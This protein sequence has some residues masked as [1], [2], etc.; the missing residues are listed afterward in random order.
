[1]PEPLLSWPHV[2]G[3][4]IT[5][6]AMQTLRANVRFPHHD[7]GGHFFLPVLD[8]NPRSST[9]SRRWSG[10]SVTNSSPELLSGADGA[11]SARWPA[12]ATVPVPARFT[13]SSYRQ[14][15]GRG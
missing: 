11:P 8:N 9:G 15:A 6:D 12:A 14:P 2:T 3:L 7:K 13:R 1:M 4:V 5:A 10:E